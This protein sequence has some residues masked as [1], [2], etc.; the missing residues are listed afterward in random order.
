[1][2]G[3]EPS[4]LSYVPAHE[5]G[6]EWAVAARQLACSPRLLVPHPSP[7]WPWLSS[8]TAERVQGMGDGTGA[9]ARCVREK[10]RGKRGSLARERR[11]RGG[12]SRG[13]AR[14]RERRE[15]ERMRLGGFHSG[16]ALGRVLHSRQT[17]VT[18]LVHEHNLS[19]IGLVE[20]K[21]R[22]GNHTPIRK[23]FLPGWAMVHNYTHN[24]SGRIWVL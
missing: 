12:G 24:S 1:M 11:G 13:R 21:V 23:E 14:T 2:R 6:E 15:K 18:S 22:D 7:V 16:R 4:G 10:G 19:L 5:R 20:T 8:L 3:R 9:F 17:D